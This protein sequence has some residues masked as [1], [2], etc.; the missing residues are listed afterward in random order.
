MNKINL[1]NSCI[2]S[3]ILLLSVSIVFAKVVNRTLATVNNEAIL[4]SEFDKKSQ[5]IIDEYR[6]IFETAPAK[7][8]EGIDIEQ[9]IKELDK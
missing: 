5:P 2:V 6:R 7:E 1:K 9:K 4:Q 8:K 3:F